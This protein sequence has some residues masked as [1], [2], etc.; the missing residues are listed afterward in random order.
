MNASSPLVRALLVLVLGT[1]PA[2]PGPTF[3]EQQYPGPP[4]SADAIAVLR[5]NGSDRPRVLGIDDEENS[6][7]HGLPSDGRLHIELLPGR[8]VVVAAKTIDALGR[9]A[10]SC[11]PESLAFDAEPG[12]VYRLL[13]IEPANDQ[14]CTRTLGVFEVDRKSD[15]TIRDVTQTV[16]AR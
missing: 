7:S 15:H 14:P 2:C 11:G 5:V 13:A 16:A 3:I 9:W 4:R 10:G 12:K 8:H 6:A 1:L